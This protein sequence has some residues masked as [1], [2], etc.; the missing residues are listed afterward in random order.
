MP[1][2]AV[3]GRRSASAGAA[4]VVVDNAQ[5]IAGSELLTGLMKM[6]GSMGA[7]VGLLLIS[8]VA[9]ASG[10]FLRDTANV[11]DPATLFVPPYRPD[12]L[13]KVRANE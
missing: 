8:G 2:A 4:W 9:W 5:R 3:V 1:L 11:A 6:R 12:Q 10:R 13:V 7:N